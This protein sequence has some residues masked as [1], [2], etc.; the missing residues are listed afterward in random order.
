[1]IVYICFCNYSANSSFALSLR[2]LGVIFVLERSYMIYMITFLA[3][4]P[5]MLYKCSTKVHP[6]TYPCENALA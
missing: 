5:A 2:Y 6:S 4:A 1:M 3:F